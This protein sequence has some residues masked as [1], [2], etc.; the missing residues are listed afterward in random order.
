MHTYVTNVILS[1][2]F[3][4]RSRELKNPGSKGYSETPLFVL[5]AKAEL[6]SVTNTVFGLGW[7]IKIREHNVCDI[8]TISIVLL[9]LS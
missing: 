2:D 9:C 8:L 6:P 5:P 4:I 1:L 3:Y 7:D